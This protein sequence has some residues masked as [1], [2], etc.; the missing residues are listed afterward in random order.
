MT[1]LSVVFLSATG[2]KAQEST[3]LLAIQTAVTN[4]MHFGDQ[5]DH[6]ALADLL[7]PQFRTVANRLFGA[8]EVSLM[9]K[10]LYLQLIKDK[11]IGGDERQLYIL[12]ME[13]VGNNATVKA[14]MEGKVLQFTTFLSLVKSPKG[15][16]TIIGDFPHIEKV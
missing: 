4:F 9:S 6:V 1:F 3:D 8:E 13:V 15:D 7:H 5:Q 16:W 11:K 2:L 10:E 12:E 14:V